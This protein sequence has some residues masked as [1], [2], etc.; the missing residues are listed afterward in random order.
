MHLAPETGVLAGGD[1][2][3]IRDC[4]FSG[5]LRGIN[6]KGADD[7][8]VDHCE[9]NLFP[10]AEWVRWGEQNDPK[11]N[12]ANVWEWVPEAVFVWHDGKRVRILNN[13]VTNAYD[14]LRPRG[15]G[16]ATPPI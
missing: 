12:W 16:K 7:L 9:Y 1:H 10:L 8:L 11:K 3:S 4:H 13:F 6:A 14:S 15:M 2:V 5:I